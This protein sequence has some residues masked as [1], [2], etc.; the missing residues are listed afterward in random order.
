MK[1]KH[2]VITKTMSCLTYALNRCGI[3]IPELTDTADI[4]K[5]FRVHELKLGSEALNLQK[6]TILM[7]TQEE[8]TELVPMEITEDGLIFTKPA[9]I[10]RHL[11]V[12]EGGQN[13][14]DCAVSS[15]N[16]PFCKYV[17]MRRFQ[18]IPV[19]SQPTHSLELKFE[20]QKP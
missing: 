4:E 12:Y 5:Y 8:R 9:L 6:G 19:K 10:L 18:D 15:R 2:V 14:S 11:A 13:I 17:R 20:Y 7:F 1:L 3:E 16:Y